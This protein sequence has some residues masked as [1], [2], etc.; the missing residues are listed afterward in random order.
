MKLRQTALVF[1]VLFAALPAFAQSPAADPGGK[2]FMWRVER[3]GTTVYLLGSIHAMKEDAYPLPSV[4]EEAFETVDAVAFEIDMDEMGSAALEMLAAGSLEAGTT[5]EEVVGAA[6]WADF[7]WRMRLA[8]FDPGVMQRFKPWMAALTLVAFEITKAGYNPS[9]GLDAYLWGRAEDAGKDRLALETV[10][11][12]VGLFADM[13]PEQSLAFL[14]YTLADLETMI[15]LLDEISAGWRSGDVASVEEDLLEGFEEYP[16]LYRK[17]VTDRNRAWLQPIEE[18]L[19]GDR[20]VMV[21]V[22]SMHLVGEEGLV[23]LLREKG[24][25]VTQE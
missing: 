20:D 15:P 23:G 17:M 25:T 1:F 3:G 4:I 24:Y 22:G 8:G 5:L 12:Q 18:L 13:T 14:S 19:A 11:F 9:A 6:T 21:V 7:S 2:S 16:D 10:A